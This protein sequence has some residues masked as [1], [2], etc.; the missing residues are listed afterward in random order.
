M[1]RTRRAQYILSCVIII[2]IWNLKSY[3]AE[4]TDLELS[5]DSIYENLPDSTFVGILSSVDPD[6]DL[7]FTYSL[8][9]GIGDDDNASFFIYGDTLFSHEIFDFETNPSYT[10][11]IQTS[12][13]AAETY[14][15]IFIITIID[16]TDITLSI[17]SIA[18]NEPVNTVVGILTGT[19]PDGHLIFTYDLVPGAGDEDNASFTIVDDELRTDEVFDF[20]AKSIYLIRIETSYDTLTYEEEFTIGIIDI[21]E[22]PNDINLSSGLVNENVAT[23]TGVGTFTTIDQDDSD[24]HTYTLVSGG[25][26]T[27]NG[28]FTIVGNELQTNATI[29]FETQNSY[30]IRVRTTDNGTTPLSYDEVFTITV[31][32]INEAP[33]DLAISSSTVDEGQAAGTAVG[34]FTTTDQDDSDTHTYTLVSGGGDTGNGSFTIVG[35]ELQTNTTLDFETQNSYSIRVRTTDNG[36]TP[37]SYDE[38]FA[39]TVNNINVAPTDLAISSST[40]DEGQAAGTAVGT[41]TT[42]DQDDS[43]THTYTLVSGGGDTGNGSFTIVGNELQTNTTLDFDS[44]NSYSIRVRT[45]DN[46]TTPLSY[47]EVFTITVNNINVAPTDLAISSSTVDEGQAAGAA[48]GTFTTTDQDNSD[49]HTYTLV[50]GGGDTGNGS[51]TI[52]GNEL[53]TNTTLDFETQNSYSIRVRTTDNGTTP[54]SYEEVFTITVNNINV[55]PT[56][57]AISSSTVD[58][59]QAAGTAVGTF[60]TTDQDDSDTHTYT[61]VSGGGDTG[62]G[63]FTIVGNELQTNTTLDFDSQNSYSIR[64][65]TTDNGTTPLSYDEVFTITVNNINVAPTDLAISS[66]TVDEGQAAGAAVGTFT[67]TDQDDSDT[68]TYTLVS[69][70][71]DTGNG[72]FTIVGNELQT[73]TTLDFETQNSYSIR[74]RTTDNGTTPL[75]YDEVFTITVN[76]INVAPTDL[77]IS[78]ST[79]DEGQAT[80]TAVGTFTTTDQDDSD[81][82]TYTL[83]SGGGDTG[84]GS[85]TIVGNELQ[86]NTTL[87]FDSQNSYSIR[88]RTTDNG[89]TPLSYDEVFTITVNNINVAPTDLAISSSTVDEGQAA[90]AAVGT[91]TTTDQDDSDT[92]TYTL[93]SGGGDTGNGSFTMVGNELQTNTTLDFDSQNSYSIRVRTTDNG[94]TPLSYDEVFAITVNNINVAPTDIA[95]SSSTVDEG[96][97]AGAAVGTFTTT[98]QDDSDTHTYTLVSG[99]GDTGN[100]SFTIVGNELQT[101]TTIDFETQNSYSIRVRTTDNGTTPLSYDEVFTI[102]VNNINVAP[103]DIAI[104]SSTVDEGQAAGTAVGTFTTTDQDD[105]DTHTYTLVSGGGDTGNGSFTIVG[106]ELQTNTAIDFE[107]QNS[108]SIRVRTTDNGTTPLSYEEVFTISINDINETPSDIILSETTVDE[109]EPVGTIVG[110]L[111]S[112]DPDAGSIFS[113]DLVGGTGSDDNSSF[114]VD[115][116][117]LQTNEIFDFETKSTYLIRIET[118]DGSLTYEEEFAISVNNVNEAPTDIILSSDTISENQPVNSVVATLSSID[119]DGEL[120]FDY[121]LVPGLGDDDNA[122]FIIVDDELLT[123]EVF[124]YEVQT[125]YLIRIQTTDPGALFYQEAFTI[126]INDINE[127]PE[128]IDIESTPLAY[129]EDE[130]ARIITST[131]SAIDPENGEM[132][133]ATI[134]ILGG[135]SPGEDRLSLLSSVFSV[136]INDATGVLTIKGEGTLGA[137]ENAL[138]NIRYVN[139]NNRNPSTADRI[140]QFTIHDDQNTSLPVTRT[141]QISDL[142]DAPDVVDDFYS[143]VFE[144]GTL[145]VVAPEGVLANDEDLDGPVIMTVELEDSVL[146]GDITLN[147]DGSFTYVHGGTDDLV[148]GFTYYASD[149]QELSEL[150]TVI[151]TMTGV[152]DPPVLSNIESTSLDYLEDD[153]PSQVTDSILITDDDDLTLQSAFIQIDFNF[154]NSEDSLVFTPD[155]AL[156]IDYAYETGNLSVSGEATLLTYQNF[157]QSIQYVNTNILNPSPNIRRVTFTV[158]DTSNISATVFRNIQVFP[159]NDPPIASEA[160]IL[161]ADFHVLQQLSADYIFT[162]PDGDP[163]GNTLFRWYMAD[164][165]LGTGNA[166]INISQNDTLTPLYQHGGKWIQYIVRPFDANSVEGEHDTSEY[167]YINAAPVLEDFTIINEIHPGAFAIGEDVRAEFS[168]ADI[169]S[170]PEDTHTFQWYRSPV[171]NW[172]NIQPIPGA[173]SEDYTITPADN[174]MYIGLEVVAHASQGSPVGKL[175]QSEWHGVS[176]TPSA[177]ISG[178]VNMCEGETDMLS[179]TLSGSNPPWSFRYV[180]EGSTDTIPVPGIPAYNSNYQLEVEEEGNYILV[181]VSDQEFDFGVITGTG[182]VNFYPKPSAQLTNSEFSIC[183]ND[184]E[185]H[186]MPVVLTGV[187]PWSLSYAAPG[188]NDP[189]IVSNIESSVLNIDFTAEDI[190][191]YQLLTVED[192]NCLVSATGTTEISLKENP[193]AE[194]SGYEIVC[195]SDTAQLSVDLTGDGP[196]TFFYTIDNGDEVAVNVNQNQSTYT[197]NLETDQTGVYRMT[198]VQNSKGEGCVY[199]LATVENHISPTATLSTDIT[200]CEGDNANIPVTLNGKSPWTI[201]YQYNIQSPKEIADIVQN[202]YMLNVSKE[203]SY[204]ITEVTDGNSCIGKGLGLAS[205][206]INPSP[207]VSILNLDTIY[208]VNTTQVPFS[209]EPE[210]GNFNLSDPSTVFEIGDV[211]FFVPFYAGSENSPHRIIYS[212]QD[213]GTACFGGDTLM[214]HVIETGGAISVKGESEKPE[215]YCFNQDTLLLNG[216]NVD[217]SLG[218][219]TIDGQ[220]GLIDNGNNTAYLIPSEIVSGTTRKRTVRYSY[221]ISGQN[222]Y[223]ERDFVFEKIDAGFTW[224]HEC[225]TSESLVKLSDN[226]ISDEPNLVSNKWKIWLNDHYLLADT[227]VLDVKFDYLDTYTIEYVTISEFGCSDT[228][229]KDLVLKPTYPVHESFYFEDFYDGASDWMQKTD[230]ESPISW[231]YGAPSGKTIIAPS[232]RAW[233]TDIETTHAKEK[234]YVISP[235]FDFSEAKRPMIKMKIW[236][237]FAFNVDGA[238]LEF[239]TNENENWFTVGGVGDGIN[240]YNS[241]TISGIPGKDGTGWTEANPVDTWQIAKHK[242]DDIPKNQGLVRFRV[243]YGA[244]LTSENEAITR[245][246]FAFDDIWVGERTKK[247]LVEYFT[248]MGIDSTIKNINQDFNSVI[249]KMNK[250]IIDLQFHMDRPGPDVFYDQDEVSSNSRDLYYSYPKV[251]FAIIDGGRGNQNAFL[252]DFASEELNE[253]DLDLAVLEDN[254]FDIELTTDIGNDYLNIDINI[255]S[256]SKLGE[257]YITLH[258]VVVERLIKDETSDWGES[259][260]ESV[261]RAM[262]P[263]AAGTSFNINWIPGTTEHVNLD[264]FYQGIYDRHEVRV[265]A[266]VQDNSNL[267]VYQAAIVNPYAAV[268][269]EQEIVEDKNLFLIYPNPAREYT[270]FTFTEPLSEGTRVE[271]VDNSG[272][273]I[274]IIE[275]EEGIQL[276]S[277]YLRD[278]EPGLYF[279]RLINND[280]LLDTQKLVILGNNW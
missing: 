181:D 82:H 97:A 104:S 185:T 116:D 93:V 106:N 280:K 275:I 109:N 278:Y 128:L 123:S 187:S 277:I 118:S 171:G 17:D 206:A 272:R 158:Y 114:T 193:R 163:E 199:G 92:H 83:V 98:D 145:I 176:E 119:P 169:E 58:E 263:D 228:I 179:V 9:A 40:V 113:Y 217:R 196:W 254:K 6:G 147:P 46:G 80:G 76:N 42:T 77:A 25:G 175:Q 74:V 7:V 239:R 243:A 173:N 5:C 136:D 1:G 190:G 229:L 38:V 203:G 2:L 105:S 50:S 22:A 36:T 162:D 135:F 115:G 244:P 207:E 146:Y 170:D 258:V 131:L 91:F 205:I 57:L 99:G 137:Y 4:P 221:T 51:F 167:R 120:I 68:H 143:D 56:D 232:E 271:I 274:R 133:S 94:T 37:L 215:R 127:P 260:F 66:S 100:G 151:I 273:L 152:N 140:I 108:Y 220:G 156:T 132:D 18:E 71:G 191:T 259:D 148:D 210:G 87:D 264:Y 183:E 192:E 233:Y 122:S 172:V 231:T 150:A 117:E 249:N 86:T 195:P 138:R 236:Q 144:G 279:V 159:Q 256:L 253:S 160:S 174:N 47:D 226:S 149:S 212:Y 59:G 60:T 213:P 52:V 8:I 81:T 218:S 245:D 242:L 73:N 209:V 62:N 165:S 161:G 75:S 32:N 267:E 134:R 188:Q 124:D 55:A 53:Q 107:T 20:E 84:N 222:E 43:D 142:N 180:I 257:K 67:T 208:T 178:I 157:L 224:D 121:T 197:Y 96:Q 64:V 189:I 15:E 112:T 251:P 89:T 265:V 261:V 270:N 153:P 95:I 26:D 200:I 111:T 65:R 141:I 90:G 72:S 3:A 69:G 12:D 24:S 155:P 204:R 19:D 29:D 31:N 23:G 216:I 10:I 103:T 198:G 154:V 211:P 45:T 125:T 101:N 16:T 234:S 34:T 30:S 237:D 182:V 129:V 54:L 201:S 139:I 266:F 102:T 241:G 164:D 48:V 250:D 240:W 247:V 223:V 110:I 14:E 248:N 41:F 202:P 186:S 235:C 230:E 28:S 70:G 21:N 252:I 49:T 225:F 85:F 44:Q 227:S 214:I 219:F 27:G 88:V 78:S 268:G 130:A 35:N 166:L 39:I 255:T 184:P 269:F 262:L 177:V 168:Y 276:Q 194:I 13:E 63:S 33:T 238:V 79:V 126:N 11:R 246:G 61:L